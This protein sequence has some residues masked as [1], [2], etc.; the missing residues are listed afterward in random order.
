VP[1]PTRRTHRRASTKAPGRIGA[2]A[3]AATIALACGGDGGDQAAAGGDAPPADGG[4]AAASSTTGFPPE[5]TGAIDQALA[6]QG[7]ELFKSRGCVAC[8]TFGG[9][10]LV[11]PDLVG[12]TERRSFDW[13]YA[14]I[15]NPD[16]MLANDETARALLAEYYTPMTN[17]NVQ[18]DEAMAL[19][20]HIRDQN[21]GGDTAAD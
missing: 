14:M 11:G 21:E 16:S 18:R 19:Y 7:A 6:A 2:F 4:Q 5:P 13:T 8:H 3:L 9:G 15:T 12:L 17:Q 20:E 1:D 10:R